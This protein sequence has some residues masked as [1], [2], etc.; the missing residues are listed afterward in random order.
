MERLMLVSCDCHAGASPEVYT[1]YLEP[2]FRDAYAQA[3]SDRAAS[4]RRAA[5]LIGAGD[6]SSDGDDERAAL[7][8]RWTPERRLGV[9]D[10]D[11]IAAE[12]IFPQPAGRAAPPFYDFFGHPR[13]PQRPELAA[14]GCRAY[15][16][17]L[18]DFLA[19]SPQPERHVGLA[20]IG[21]V[22]DVDAA[23]AEVEGAKRSGLGG[24]ILRSQPLEG[25]GWH[26]PRYARLWAACESLEMPIHTHGGE[27]LPLGNH[28]GS[29]SIFFTEVCWFAHRIFWHLLWSGVLERHPRLNLV[30]AEQFA[31]W[32]PGVLQ[33]L[34]VQY[35][36]TVS[37]LTLAEGLSMKPSAYWARQCHVGASF[38]SRAECEMRH[39]IG[40]PT[41]LWGSDF[42]HDEGTWPDTA[43]ALRETF[44]GVPEDELRPMLGENALRLY[45]L[46]RTSIEGHA[47]RVGPTFEQVSGTAG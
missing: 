19:D 11:G 26:D 17:W 5:E 39:A 34:D 27:G 10:A 38:M 13:D 31:D 14:A 25:V 15:N 21:V 18:V 46:D 2:A 32:V 45:G 16:R 6:M 40:V 8:G 47:A 3:I 37:T 9:L 22:D 35:E 30:F 23:V 24:I 33:R 29:R 41:I 42:P 28:P 43:S 36:G 7:T 44:R 12:V 4:L 1:D 20:L